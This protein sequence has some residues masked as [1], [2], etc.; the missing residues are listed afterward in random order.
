MNL[1]TI[2]DRFVEKTRGQKSR[3]TVP[4]TIDIIIVKGNYKALKL[5]LKA[6]SKAKYYQ[7]CVQIYMRQQINIS[8]R[9]KGG[10]EGGIVWPCS[11]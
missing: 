5:C 9:F 3:A 11:L 6:H 4:L 2:W 1:G 8:E 7:Y 10:G